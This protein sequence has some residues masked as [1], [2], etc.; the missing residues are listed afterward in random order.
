MGR[1]N[2]NAPDRF[3]VDPSGGVVPMVACRP[4]T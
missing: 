2:A 1:A 4:N 3:I